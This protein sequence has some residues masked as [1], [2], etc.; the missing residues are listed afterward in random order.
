[1]AASTPAMWVAVLLEQ[2]I[3]ESFLSCAGHVEVDVV[4]SSSQPKNDVGG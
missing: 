1:M 3:K 2:K 4:A